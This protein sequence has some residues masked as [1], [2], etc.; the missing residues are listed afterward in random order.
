MKFRSCMIL[1]RLEEIVYVM[2]CFFLVR[3]FLCIENK[4]SLREKHVSWRGCFNGTE[5]ILINII[6]VKKTNK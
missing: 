3:L 2:F 6:E 4:V 5:F 1:N